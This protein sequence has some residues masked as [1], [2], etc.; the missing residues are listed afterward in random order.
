MGINVITRSLTALTMRQDRAG[1]PTAV[2]HNQTPGRTCRTELP[3]QRNMVGQADSK[4]TA[5]IGAFC[6]VPFVRYY[7]D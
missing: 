1:P 5:Q 3:Q 2:Q 7:R 6:A 4:I